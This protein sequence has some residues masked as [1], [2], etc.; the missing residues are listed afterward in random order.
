VFIFVGIK[1]DT[2]FLKDILKLDDLGFIITDQDAKTSV[3]GIFA[4]GD[5]SKKSLYQVISACSEGAV[6][7]A[8]VHNYLI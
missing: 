3:T 4:C 6:A 2:D 8:G 1:P 7:A 5:C